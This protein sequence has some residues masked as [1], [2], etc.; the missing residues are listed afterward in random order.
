MLTRELL[1]RSATDRDRQSLANLIHFEVYVHRHLDWRPPIDWIGRQP[2]LVAERDGHILSALICPPDPP[3]AAWIRLFIVSQDIALEEGWQ[4]LWSG[5]IEQLN[6]QSRPPIAAIALRPWFRDLLEKSGFEQTQEIISLAWDRTK[7]ISKVENPT[8]SIRPMEDFDL[9][10][11]HALDLTAFGFIWKISL[12]TL[13]NAYKQ[14][15]VASVAEVDGELVG[16]QISTA[17]PMGGHLARLAVTPSYQGKGIG[18]ALVHDVLEK[19]ERRDAMRVTVNTQ[20]DNL[21]SLAVYEKA[22]FRPTSEIL[23]VFQYGW[24]V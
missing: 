20:R 23:P 8:A 17:G 2:C 1:I 18:T 22:G 10:S 12:D 16:Y 9:K 7:P 24:M 11:V 21:S 15:C 14:S 5:A 19:F 6:R 3:E 4:S 13:T